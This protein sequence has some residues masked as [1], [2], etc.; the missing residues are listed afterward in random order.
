MA[1]TE[2]E[3]KALTTEDSGRRLS[4][5]SSLT[6]WV[7]LDRS[8]RVIVFFA[9]R[10]RYSGRIHAIGCGTW[11]DDKLSAIRKQRD[12]YRGE[13]LQ[14]RNPLADKEAAKLQAQADQTAIKAKA[15]A[16]LDALTAAQARMTVRDLFDRWEIFVLKDRKD[17]GAEVRRMFEK[18]VLTE[19]GAI[20]VED[21]KRRHIAAM[22]DKIKERGV[23]RMVNLMLAQVRQMFRFAVSRDWIESDPTAALKKAD[24]GGKEVERERTLSEAEIRELVEKLPAGKLMPTT[25]ASIW[26]MLA[27]C[28]RV[29]EIS[30]AKWSDIDLDGR[31]WRIPPGNSKNKRE[32]I[33]TLSNF[34]VRQF[35]VLRRY[36]TSPIW[37]FPAKQRNANEPETNVDGKSITKQIHDRQRESKMNGRSKAT[38]TLL[39]AGGPWTPHDL[40]RTG[41]TLM[42]ELGVDGDVIERCL[43]HIEPNRIKRT[44]QRQRTDE[45]KADAWRLL[46]ERLEFLTT[47]ANS[48]A[49]TKRRRKSAA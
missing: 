47:T 17:K 31:K 19:I 2:L 14:G 44:Y 27:T 33:I 38:A 3:L 40:R 32:H 23:G 20:A 36:Q 13:V 24:F 7:R 46:G 21:V 37:I 22:L 41:A 49:T 16:Q 12:A 34:A 35:E 26:I 48:V 9:Y 39:L 1:I 18:D 25:E 6:G 28:C 11:P 43:N 5:G 10:Y 15:Q 4:D 45:A 8:G 29:G 42:G 30:K